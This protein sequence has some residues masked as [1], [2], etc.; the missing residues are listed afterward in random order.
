MHGISVYG[1]RGGE[2]DAFSDYS[3]TIDT[4]SLDGNESDIDESMPALVPAS[5]STVRPP[6]FPRWVPR[7]ASASSTSS[8]VSSLSPR[9]Q[10]ERAI[11]VRTNLD[12][13]PPARQI[14]PPPA[15]TSSTLGPDIASQPKVPVAPSAS[16]SPKK[17]QSHPPP[18]ATA[19]AAAAAAFANTI[20]KAK[21]SNTAT[22]SSLPPA[23]EPVPAPPT[24]AVPAEPEK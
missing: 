11:N 21:A 23:A 20:S 2:T 22:T 24:T 14:S 9:C 8:Y 6:L 7:P 19:T 1:L 10:N 13:A 3:N 17:R 16:S 5:P 4:G 12:E 15:A 18:S